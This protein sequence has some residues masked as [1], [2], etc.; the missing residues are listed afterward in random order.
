M[1]SMHTPFAVL[2]DGYG[3]RVGPSG[4]VAVGDLS[5]GPGRRIASTTLYSTSSAV[6]H[7]PSPKDTRSCPSCSPS[8]LTIAHHVGSPLFRRTRSKLTGRVLSLSGGL[9]ARTLATAMLVRQELWW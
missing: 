7:A 3:L 4:D 6:L 1:T 8:L 9:S 2:G 5:D